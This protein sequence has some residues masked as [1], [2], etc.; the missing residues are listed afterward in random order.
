MAELLHNQGMRTI[1]AGAKGVVLLEVRA[2][3]PGNALGI[4]LFAGEVLPDRYARQLTGRWESFPRKDR[5]PGTRSLDYTRFNWAVMGQR[6][7]PL[8]LVVVE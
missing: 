4:N 1:I 6:G 7:A 2:T 5:R 3:R 8:L